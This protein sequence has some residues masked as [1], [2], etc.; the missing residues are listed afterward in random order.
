MK[1]GSAISII[2]FLIASF[3][4]AQK[5]G[6]NWYFGQEAGLRFHNGYPE[7]MSGKLS[8]S[9]GCATISDEDGY[10]QFYT[11]GITVWNRQHLVMQNGT[12]LYG[13]SSSTQSGVIVPVPGDTNIYYIFTVSNLDKKGKGVG[14]CYSKVDM[15]LDYGNGAITEKNVLLFSST[16]ERITS[17]KHQNDYGVWVIGPE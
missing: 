1:F 15:R 10:L 2:F 4:F 3:C 17:V 16:T 6:L 9:E 14:F 13:N 5:E 7:P 8:T 12:G 11:D